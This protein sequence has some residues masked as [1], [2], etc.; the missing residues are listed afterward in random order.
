MRRIVTW[1]RRLVGVALL[2]WAAWQIV[3]IA[4]RPG[5][6]LVGYTIG[7][8]PRGLDL[9]EAMVVAGALEDARAAADCGCADPE[10]VTLAVPSAE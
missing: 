5:E 6:Q 8:R 3:R 2:G 10:L 9:F 4:T 1:I 7:P